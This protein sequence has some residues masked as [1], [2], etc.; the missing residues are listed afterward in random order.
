[1]LTI[2]VCELSTA[3]VC[4]AAAQAPT[5]WG[6]SEMRAE[7]ENI[8]VTIL[9]D[10]Y[11][12]DPRL[13][14]GWGFAAVLEYDDHAVLFDTGADGPALLANLRTLAIDPHTIEA[15]VL[16]HAH[17]DHTGGLEGLLETGARPTVYLLPSFPERFKRRIGSLTTVVETEADRYIGDRISTTGE[18][19]GGIPEQALIVETSRGLV[20]LT[21][22]AH[23][24]VAH[25]VARA[26]A[27]RSQPVHLVLGGFHLRNSGPE[28]LRAL[29]AEFRRLGVE[30]VAPC[31]CTGDPAIEMFSAEY[32]KNFIR[33][34][35]GL[36]ISVEWVGSRPPR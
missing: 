1:M 14:S 20:I 21:G 8:K 18:L 10:N 29:I 5:R 26:M 36:V 9:Y 24:G 32:G 30:R 25:I 7:A 12:H 19:D 22:C 27:L 35:V 34:G 3:L 31:H 23:P 33:A 28:Q 17:G 4:M 15:V 2:G 6:E 16:S 11:R 13:E